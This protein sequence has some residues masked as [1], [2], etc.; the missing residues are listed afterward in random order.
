[1]LQILKGLAEV[2]RW[3]GTHRGSWRGEDEGIRFNVCVASLLQVLPSY[4]R[5]I[6]RGM[7]KGKAQVL[8]KET[9]DQELTELIF[10]LEIYK[11]VQGLYIQKPE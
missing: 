3:K 1:M 2:W 7:E 10:K 4:F 5:G 8:E 11:W 6:E 9:G